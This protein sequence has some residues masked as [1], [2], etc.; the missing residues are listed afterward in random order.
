MGKTMQSVVNGDTISEKNTSEDVNRKMNRCPLSEPGIYQR[1][2]EDKMVQTFAVNPN[3][4]ESLVLPADSECLERLGVNMADVNS[5]ERAMQ[6]QRQLQAIE[7]EAQQGWW[8]WL[9]I[10]VLGL[11]GTESAVCII[12]SR[13]K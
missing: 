4:S 6:K 7:L 2:R 10:G 11:A 5:P 1:W 9:V 3:E 12:R 8:R 13:S